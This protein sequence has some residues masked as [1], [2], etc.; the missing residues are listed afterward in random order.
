ML[1]FVELLLYI[2][3]SCYFYLKVLF[4]YRLL[5]AELKVCIHSYHIFEYIG[6]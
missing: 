4:F 2:D 3:L 5:F 6:L 1:S